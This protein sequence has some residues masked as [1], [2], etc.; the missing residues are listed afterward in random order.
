MSD[1]TDMSI[2]ES[3]RSCP[4]ANLSRFLIIFSFENDVLADADV[5]GIV[6]GILT[7]LDKFRKHSDSWSSAR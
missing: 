2:S 7:I 6:R 4:I 1:S 5:N 3:S